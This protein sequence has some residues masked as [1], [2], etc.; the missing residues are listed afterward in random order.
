MQLI[1]VKQSGKGIKQGDVV[2]YG[3]NYYLATGEADSDGDVYVVDAEQDTNYI[4][5]RYLT[6]IVSAGKELEQPVVTI[7]MTVDE[8]KVLV[9]ATGAVSREEIAEELSRNGHATTLSRYGRSNYE[10]LRGILKEV[11]K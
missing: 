1:E 3:G 10:T 2:E 4:N 8:L 5:E 7:E 9:T 6:K 11:A